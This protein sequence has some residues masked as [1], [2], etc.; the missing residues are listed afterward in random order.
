MTRDELEQ[1]VREQIAQVR[2]HP[3]AWVRAVDKILG[4]AGDYAVAEG[5]KLAE[6][7]R[8]LEKDGGW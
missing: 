2:M 3:D 6:R 7:R 4:A 8:V 1:V 5:W